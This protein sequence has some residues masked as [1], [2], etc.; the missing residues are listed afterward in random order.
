MQ[1]IKFKNE[2]TILAAIDSRRDKAHSWQTGYVLGTSLAS[3]S[4]S[5]IARTPVAV[6]SHL[7]LPEKVKAQHRRRAPVMWPEAKASLSEFKAP[8]PSPTPSGGAHGSKYHAEDTGWLQVLGKSKAGIFISPFLFH[9]SLQNNDPELNVKYGR[10]YIFPMSQEASF[11]YLSSKEKSQQN[12]LKRSLLEVPGKIHTPWCCK[13]S[14]R[15]LLPLWGVSL[16]LTV[17]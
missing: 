2:T 7:R 8:S 14:V 11:L 12:P 17:E 4:A 3:Y 15:W 16:K 6:G 10:K 13:N 5:L 9:N 1:V